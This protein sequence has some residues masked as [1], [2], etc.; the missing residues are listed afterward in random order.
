LGIEIIRTAWEEFLEF[1][2]NT[3][4]RYRGWPDRNVMLA[5]NAG[6][7]RITY[8][9]PETMWPGVTALREKRPILIVDF[10][11]MKD[12]SAQQMAE[13]MGTRWPGLRARRLTFPYSFPG[14][15]RQNV[16]MAEALEAPEV[17]T[18]LAE[19]IRP[20]L[21][22]A[23]LV[24]MPAILGVQQP[25]EI[26]ADLERQIGVPIFEIPT[27]PPSVPGLRLKEVLGQGLQRGGAIRVSGR[28]VVAVNGK[29]RQCFSVMVEGGL[30][31]ETLEARGIV[32]A[33]GRFLGGG[34]AASRSTVRETLLDLPVYQPG[35]R[36]QWHRQNFLDPRGHP[37]NRA[38]LEVD[39]LLRPLGA[40]GTPA[41]ENLFAAGS[42]LAHHDWMRMKC[43]A[44]LAIATAYGAVQCFL[45]SC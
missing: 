7:V 25:E 23:E 34:L 10:E 31:Q 24:G 37:V 20:L 45:E 14:V 16:L 44:G 8:R 21:A 42:I 15:E 35:R 28:R 27:L 6:T 13:T 40:D 4:L 19:S 41:Y 11:G 33:T 29:G 30:S 36:Q 9:V 17:R 18:D 2:N 32:L 26:V 3:G 1:L 12:F 39:D 38:G 5:T 43:G 22:D